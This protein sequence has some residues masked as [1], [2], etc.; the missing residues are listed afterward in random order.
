MK[1]PQLQA[2]ETELHKEIQKDRFML[3]L[4]SGYRALQRENETLKK[5]RIELLVQLREGGWDIV[6]EESFEFPAV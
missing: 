4:I 1:E 5:K 2:M 6:E 3:D